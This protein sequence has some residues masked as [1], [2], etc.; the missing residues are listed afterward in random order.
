MASTGEMT[1][2]C[3]EPP[4]AEWTKVFPPNAACVVSLV[5]RAEIIPIVS[6]SYRFKEAQKRSDARKKTRKKSGGGKPK[7]GNGSTDGESPT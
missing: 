5:D 4:F 6:E 2:P 7:R 1:P 3:G